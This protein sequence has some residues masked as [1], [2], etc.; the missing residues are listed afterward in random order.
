MEVAR[1][2]CTRTEDAS[3]GQDGGGGREWDF[4]TK[5]I[6]KKVGKVGGVIH[7][8]GVLYIQYTGKMRKERREDNNDCDADKRTRTASAAAAGH[9]SSSNYDIDN[10]SLEREAVFPMHP[11]QSPLLHSPF[12]KRPRPVVR[13]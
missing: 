8:A 9:P 11:A 4:P 6:N 1:R 5:L 12:C 10:S 7:I 2:K 13:G 3:D